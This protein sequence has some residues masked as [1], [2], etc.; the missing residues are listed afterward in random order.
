MGRILVVGSGGPHDAAAEPITR[1]V[2]PTG[3]RP[4][5]YTLVSPTDGLTN[6]EVDPADALG[7]NGVTKSGPTLQD[8]RVNGHGQD[9]LIGSVWRGPTSGEWDV[10]S[11]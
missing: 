1:V 11:C 8:G 4:Q 6:Y 7:P 5:G 3:Y 9:D 10:G 2:G